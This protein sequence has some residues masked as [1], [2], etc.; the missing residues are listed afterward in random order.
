M[1]TISPAPTASESSP[2]KSS[3]PYT[4][5]L[6]SIHPIDINTKTGE[7][8]ALTCYLRM[9]KDKLEEWTFPGMEH[10]TLRTFLDCCRAGFIL[11]F[12]RD[13]KDIVGFGS[14]LQ[15]EYPEQKR[16]PGD[17][18]QNG[19]ASGM[20]CFFKEWHRDP[21]IRH[22]ANLALRYW[23][24]QFH[25][26][27]I[28]GSALADNTPARLFAKRLGFVDCGTVPSFFWKENHPEGA[29]ILALER[30]TFYKVQ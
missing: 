15:L 23:F 16:N 2:A 20:Y 17:P 29:V 6:A 14:L 7:E 22:A 9:Q 8:A 21:V 25:L 19:K 1:S 27:L 12:D 26:R 3:W 13:H 24:E 4:D 18:F 30:D 28:M 11:G 10:P 5:E